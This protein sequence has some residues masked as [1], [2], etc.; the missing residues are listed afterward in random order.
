MTFHNIQEILT[1]LNQEKENNPGLADFIDLQS[2]LLKAQSQVIFLPV[3]QKPGTEAVRARFQE[4]TPLCHPEEMAL[5]WA[6]VADLY[7]QVCQIS[8]QYRSDL[9]AQ[10]QALLSLPDEHPDRLRTLMTAFL[11]EGR[12]EPAEVREHYELLTFAL[13]QTLSPFLQ[14]YAAA[15]VPAVTTELE[16]WQRG[17]CPICGGEPD[18]AYLDKESG[19]RHLVC[20]R[21]DTEWPFPRVKCPF[22]RTVNS[23]HLSYYPTEDEQHRLYVCRNCQRY[24]KTVDRRKAGKPFP[25][26]VE[27]V[28]TI[29]LDVVARDEGYN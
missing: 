29:A 23:K 5:E 2:E 25:V 26:P 18:L 14:A 28:I 21:C 24:L 22:C 4:G 19:A 15:L 1:Q 16:R 11:G 13:T 6:A 8:A 12:L 10:F 9:A 7:R 27:R 20:S 17:Y 3:V